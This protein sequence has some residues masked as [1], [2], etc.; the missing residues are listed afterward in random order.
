MP[1]GYLV[2]GKLKRAGSKNGLMA[3]AVN[4][5]LRRNKK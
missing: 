2:P 3:N 1:S 4:A 5:M